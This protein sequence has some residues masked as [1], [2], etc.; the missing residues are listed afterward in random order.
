MITYTNTLAAGIAVLGMTAV[1]SNAGVIDL[2]TTFGFTDLE[3][4]YNTNTGEYIAQ[5]S[6]MTSGDV[7]RH[8]L[9]SPITAAFGA[10]EIGVGNLA[11]VAFSMNITNTFGTGADGVNGQ[12]SITD[13]DG[14][15]LTGSFD[16]SWTFLGG[17]G[18]F[19]GIIDFAAYNSTG[20]GVFEG[21]GANGEFNNP[22][23]SLHGA[24]SFLIQMPEWFDTTN[25]FDN[26]TSQGDGILLTP[27]PG[28]VS[29]LAIGGLAATRRRRS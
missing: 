1:V 26:R 25:G 14:D 2:S 18:F 24:I 19:D 13:L 21:T 22:T 7:T 3:T 9:F 6:L 4:S 20:N 17:F 15:T 11:S 5:S 23:D 12:L 16:G 28:S 8:D 10:G 29:L 27:T